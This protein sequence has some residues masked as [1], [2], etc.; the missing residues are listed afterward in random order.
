MAA[1]WALHAEDSKQQ[2]MVEATCAGRMH[3]RCASSQSAE[4]NGPTWVCDDLAPWRQP[5]RSMVAR[6]GSGFA[7]HF[8]CQCSVNHDLQ[9]CV[10]MVNSFIVLRF[11]SSTRAWCIQ[12]RVFHCSNVRTD[13][14]FP[15]TSTETAKSRTQAGSRRSRY[16][17]APS[18][19]I[20][21]R[22]AQP[23]ARASG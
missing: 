2:Q 15:S 16:H 22:M 11:S 10:R 14:T 21:P 1:A 13:C 5:R 12:H 6:S 8:L 17:T 20:C 18:S 23:R 9:P 19:L 7:A 4:R 3:A